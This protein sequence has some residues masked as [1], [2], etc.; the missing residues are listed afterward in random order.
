MRAHKNLQFWPY[1]HFIVQIVQKKSPS[2]LISKFWPYN[3]QKTAI[4]PHSSYLLQRSSSTSTVLTEK[5]VVLPLLTRIAHLRTFPTPRW[6]P[7]FNPLVYWY[8][9]LRKSVKLTR[10][11]TFT[12]GTCSCRTT[13]WFMRRETR[14]C[15]TCSVELAAVDLQM[16]DL[17]L[18]HAYG[19][20]SCEACT[21]NFL[22]LCL[23]L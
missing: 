3:L 17:E 5:P 18:V 8:H 13:S 15:G 4:H 9:S 19:T 1:F 20:C 22:L 10:C 2:L 12:C 6:R 23:C 14:S 7:I 21:S 11:L 16:R